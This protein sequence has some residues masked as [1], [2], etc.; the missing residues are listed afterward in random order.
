MRQEQSIWVRVGKALRSQ[1]VDTT[2]EPLPRRWVD[3]I[4]YLN[5]QERRRSQPRQRKAEQRERWRRAN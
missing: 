5:E 1:M 3:L 2:Q 4:H